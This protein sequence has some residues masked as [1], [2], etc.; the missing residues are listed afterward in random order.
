MLTLLSPV[1]SLLNNVLSLNL[2]NTLTCVL[3]CSQTQTRV[4]LVPDNPIKL[5]INLDV[6]HGDGKVTDYNCSTPA[7]KSLTAAATT[8]V[9]N[10][11]VGQMSAAQEAAIFSS[12]VVPTVTPLPLMDVETSTRTCTL[13]LFC[14]NTAWSKYS[15]TGLKADTSVGSSSATLT[16]SNPPDLNAPPPQYQS[17]STTN[18]V[19]SLSST[20]SGLQLQT[21]YYN[22]A[23]TNGLGNLIGTATQLVSSAIAQVQTVVAALLSPMLD[24]LVNLLLTTLGIDLAKTEVGGSM[25]CKGD[26]RLVY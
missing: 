15:R 14:S 19:N 4:V 11:R 6:A 16:Y 22:A 18:V 23:A 26:A 13:L 7:S 21:Y 20:L 17:L 9:A 1:T 3:S 5:D 2:V 10:L 8:A 12:S 25:T 24:P